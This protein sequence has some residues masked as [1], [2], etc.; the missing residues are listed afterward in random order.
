MTDWASST[1]DLLLGLFEG[2]SREPVLLPAELVV[3]ESA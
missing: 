3:R 1:V 2:G